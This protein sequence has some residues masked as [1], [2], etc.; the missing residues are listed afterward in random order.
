MDSK[1]AWIRELWSRRT[2]D[3]FEGYGFERVGLV[4]SKY[5]VSK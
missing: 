5:M 2:E 4:G 3:G 1:F